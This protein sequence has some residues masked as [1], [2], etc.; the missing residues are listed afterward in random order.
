MQQRPTS[1]ALATP[2]PEVWKRMEQLEDPLPSKRFFQELATLVENSAETASQE[3]SSFTAANQ[4]DIQAHHAQHDIRT[5]KRELKTLKDRQQDLMKRHNE[6]PELADVQRDT[7]DAVDRLQK[8]TLAIPKV[9]LIMS[10][11][12]YPKEKEE[13]SRTIGAYRAVARGRTRYDCRAA[14]QGV[15]G[16]AQSTR[17]GNI[18]LSLQG[19]S[20]S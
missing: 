2:P 3:L 20:H 17:R 7:A 11:A 9:D 6:S 8:L 15:P 4:S 10:C 14:F 16:R 18:E 19:K 12:I 13:A 1:P 5:I